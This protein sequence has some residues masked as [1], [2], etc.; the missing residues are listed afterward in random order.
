VDDLETREIG[1]SSLNAAE[2]A[3]DLSDEDKAFADPTKAIL[4]S[5]EAY[6]GISETEFRARFRE[7]LHHTLEIQTYEAIHKKKGLTENRKSTVV[8]LL[9]LWER[10]GL[11]KELPDYKFAQKLLEFAD[12]LI[13]GK[14]VSLAQYQWHVLD[15]KEQDVFDKV[16]YERRSVRH[17]DWNRDVPEDIIRKLLKAGLWAAH[18]CNLQSI[19]Y[20]VVRE[21]NHPGLFTGS[22]IPGGP[23][24][25]VV[26]QDERVYLANPRNP[27]KN[28]LLD[29]GAAAQNIVL[30][31]HA[32]GLGGCWLTFSDGMLARLRKHFELP[33][34][35]QLVTYVDV[36]WPVQTPYPV[37]R[38]GVEEALIEL[39]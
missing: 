31:A 7:R 1:L 24:H 25:I 29:S 28:R 22:D 21:K 3:T 17:W 5:D 4:L 30:A 15:E 12:D 23:V 11:S 33:D 18:S 16:L 26:L 35:L 8:R 38:I 39:V 34:H 14:E 27:V 32:H 6:L 10:R 37:Q 9:G 2:K 20:L 19:R 36:G 13:D